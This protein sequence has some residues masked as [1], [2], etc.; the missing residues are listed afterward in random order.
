MNW[1]S[2]VIFKGREIIETAIVYRQS[3]NRGVPFHGLNHWPEKTRHQ[4]CEALL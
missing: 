3:A 1:A 4:K 2:F